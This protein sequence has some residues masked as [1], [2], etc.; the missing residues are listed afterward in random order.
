MSDFS[1]DLC[2]FL[3]VTGE[4]LVC[5]RCGRQPADGEQYTF[6]EDDQVPCSDCEEARETGL[7]GPGQGASGKPM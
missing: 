7:L 2:A 6:D 3:V 4:T 5:S 1:E